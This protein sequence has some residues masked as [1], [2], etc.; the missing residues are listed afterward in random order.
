MDTLKEKAEIKESVKNWLKDKHNLIFLAILLLAALMHLSN[1][2]LT[3]TQVL[4]W[5]EADY[6]AYAKNLAGFQVNW[7]IAEKHNS[8]YPYLAA[9]FF[10]VGFGESG[11]KFFLQ[12][13]PAILSVALVYFISNKM[14][15]DKKIGLII[16]FLMAT[17]WVNLFNATRFHIDI[18]ALFIG[19]IS[20]FIFWQG[21]ENKEKIFGKIN[22]KWTIPLAAVLVVLAYAIRRGYFL[23]GLFVIAYMILTRNW[24][25]LVKDKYNWIAVGIGLILFFFVEKT[26]FIS[27]IADV[28]GEFYHEELAIKPL[29]YLN[30]FKLFFKLGHFD[31]L[32]YLFWIGFILIAGKIIFSFGQI[33]K[34]PA[35]KSDLF[36]ILIIIITLA[37]FIFVLRNS[38]DASGNFIDEPRWYL[39]MA[40]ACFILIARSAV[41]ITDYIKP[42]SKQAAIII[43]CALIA[44]GG[45]YEYKLGTDSIKTKVDSFQGI[46]EASL[47]IKEMS[48]KDDLILTLG[49]PQV[50]YYSERST[51]NARV[52]AGPYSQENMSSHFE[53]TMQKIKND[54][55]VR[56]VIITFSEPAYPDWAKKVSY[57]QNGA[58]I[59]EIPFMQTKIDFSTG[60]QQIN[61]EIKYDEYELTFKLIAIKEEVFIYEIVR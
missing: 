14:Y 12:V 18:P 21:Y 60:Q 53:E 49:Q 17:F 52:W 7:I 19:L 48:S 15:K 6:M 34:T 56:F 20:I 10:K 26:I 39:P 45:Y 37:F 9:A 33:K 38:P 1:F 13:I 41:T 24:K 35:V 46:K 32:F 4:W 3:Q 11:I 50:E 59:W 27:A 25:D 31:T 55:K 57:N 28:S 58:A 47:L 22:P 2:N 23:F 44:V 51:L 42:Y 8:L 40:L 16:S 36:S 43:L 30:V 29:I 54:P 5:D 61:Q